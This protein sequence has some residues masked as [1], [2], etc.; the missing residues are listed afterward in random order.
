[1]EST[2]QGGGE[3]LMASTDAE[4]RHPPLD[5]IL[6]QGQLGYVPSYVGGLALALILLP[7]CDALLA[8]LLSGTNTTTVELVNNSDFDVDVILYYDDTQEIPDFLLTETGTLVEVTVAAGQTHRFS[9]SCD[10]LQAII[11]DDADLLV[12]GGIGPETSSDVLRDGEDFSCGS[13]VRFTFDHTAAILDFDVTTTNV[14][15]S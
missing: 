12:I 4:D 3:H 6:N 7:G 1:M 11:I 2:P 14:S 5:G 8:I 13:T 10:E 15:G 9:R